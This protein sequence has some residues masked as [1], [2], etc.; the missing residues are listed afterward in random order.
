MSALS[1]VSDQVISTGGVELAR[2]AVSDATQCLSNCAKRPVTFITEPCVHGVVRCGKALRETDYGSA[3]SN[4]RS[5]DLAST[6]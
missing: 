4:R 2:V 6:M 1:A 5:N 3:I